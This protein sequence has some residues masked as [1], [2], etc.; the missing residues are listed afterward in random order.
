MA[1]TTAAYGFP[2]PTGSDLVRNG[3]NAM[4][5][6]AQAVEDLLDGTFI[7]FYEDTSSTSQ[8]STSSSYA[9]KTD[10]QVTF[11]TGKSGKFQVILE[12]DLESTNATTTTAVASV[13]IT[14]STTVAGAD[15]FSVKNQGVDPIRASVSK[16]F[17]GTPST[18][19]TVTLCI[20]S[21]GG[22]NIIVNS[23][24]IQVVTVG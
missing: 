2:Y 1:G 21:A 14:G 22:A 4:Q 16:W 18:S 23:A 9:N 7:Q 10:T 24:R 6:L 5:S 12:A 11:T 13:D 8:T 15:T 17:T 19:T 20:R 3:D